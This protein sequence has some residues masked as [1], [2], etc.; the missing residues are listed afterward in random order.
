MSHRK[1]IKAQRSVQ[2]L[3]IR[4]SQC[5]LSAY[6]VSAPML[7]LGAYNSYLAF[8]KWLLCAQRII[9]AKHCSKCFISLT[10]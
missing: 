4:F 3:Q 9:C 2:K 10:S 5:I 1:K 6:C 7:G 8:I